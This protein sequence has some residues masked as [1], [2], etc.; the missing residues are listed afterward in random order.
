M[1]NR[2]ALIIVIMLSFCLSSFSVVP[3]SVFDTQSQNSSLLNT[4]GSVYIPGTDITEQ[5]KSDFSAGLDITLPAGHFYISESIIVQGYSGNV[6]GAGMDET[7][8]EAAQGFKPLPDPFFSSF[9][10]DIKTTEMFAVYWSKGDVTF[11]D[12]TLIITGDAPAQ[13][14]LNPFVG[15]RTTIDNAI[16]VAAVSPE[17]E[18][19][20]TVTFKN[21]RVAGENST[22]SGSYNGKNLLFPLIITGWGGNTSIN[23][24]IKNCEVD[25]SGL[26]GIE[27]FD[28]FEGSAEIIGNQIT[29]SVAGIWLGYGLAS[30]EVTVK[31]NIFMNITFNSI[32]TILPIESY[33][34]KNNILDGAI[35]ADDCSH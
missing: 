31:D 13:P 35:I 20:I 5:L 24:I 7:I 17:I 14:H 6:K 30:A 28:A 2:N 32:Q 9:P 33:C 1:M 12:M 22:D 11:K 21:I 29:N 10:G 15:E 18:N 26:Y 19:S 16:V 34:I 27:Y 3:G 23:A 8:I 25:N 4:Y